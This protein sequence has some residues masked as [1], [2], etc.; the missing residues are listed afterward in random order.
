MLKIA[1]LDTQAVEYGTRCAYLLNRKETNI[2]QP[3]RNMNTT[4]KQVALDRIDGWI[5]G[6]SV[7]YYD[8][9]MHRY[10]V[11]P[12][13]DLDYLCELMASDDEDISGSAYSH[14]CA[15]TTHGDGY[16]T[17]EAAEAAAA[18]A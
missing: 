12:A 3:K 8:D 11:G 18:I 16:E 10:Y 14:W 5:V 7:I 6:N 4:Q 2:G 13:G 9:S 17:R 15:G 1:Q